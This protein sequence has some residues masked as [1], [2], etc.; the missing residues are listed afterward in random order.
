MIIKG[1][2]LKYLADL[3][4]PEFNHIIKCN[5]NN[6]EKC[7]NKKKE[8]SSKAIPK[9]LVVSIDRYIDR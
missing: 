8:K 7:N 4:C 6:H 1:F 5:E 9:N 3:Y 2:V